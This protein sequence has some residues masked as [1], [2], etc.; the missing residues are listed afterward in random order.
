[1]KS[2]PLVQFYESFGQVY[3]ESLKQSCPL[4]GMSIS[5]LNIH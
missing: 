2:Q 5:A 1:M 4:E 3:G